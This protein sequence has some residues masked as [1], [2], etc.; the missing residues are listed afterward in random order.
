MRFCIKAFLIITFVSCAVESNISEKYSDKD[1]IEEHLTSI[2]KIDGFRNYKNTQA[3]NFVA[4]YIYSNF[5]EYCDTVCYQSYYVDGVQYKNVIGSIGTKNKERIIVGAHYDVC[6]NQEGADDNASGVVGLIELARLL[7]GQSTKYRIDLVA[8]SLEEPP[9]FRTENMGSY[10]HAK[11]LK[12][13]NISVK[14][15]ICLEMI[16]YYSEEPKSQQ[17]P[18]PHKKLIYGDE[19]NYIMIVEKIGNNKFANE[20][21]SSMKKAELIETKSIK[22]PIS[23]PGIDFSDHMNY[24][25][26]EYSALMITNTAF[27]RNQNY[28]EPSDKMETLDLPKMASVIDEVYYALKNL[29]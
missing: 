11:S 17:Y 1:K 21:K 5:L 4:D 12:E 18:L 24:W 2:T 16:G 6:G 22:A 27:F 8:Y 3:L 25:E 23:L 9:F 29:K 14:G 7:N 10:V 19:A 15:M 26:F 13:S 28:H 20:I